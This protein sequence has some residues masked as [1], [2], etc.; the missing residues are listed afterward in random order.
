MLDVE[1]CQIL[2]AGN[3]IFRRGVASIVRDVVPGA[4]VVEA[5]SFA[6]ARARLN[7]AEFFAAIFDVD[8]DEL[9]GP[10]SFRTLRAHCPDVI[11]GVLSRT[12]S[13]SDI[14]SY[15]AAGVTGYVVEA[16]GQA[17]VERAVR[18]ILK[19]AIYIPP[20]VIEPSA[21]EPE[22]ALPALR[23]N[24]CHLTPRQNGVL[25]LVLRGYSNKE[26]ARQLNLSPHTVKIHVSALLRCFAVQKRSSLAVAAAAL[27]AD[28]IGRSTVRT[29]SQMLPI[30][31]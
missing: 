28:G 16:S 13:A 18:E 21:C 19:G 7:R 30:S 8:V 20:H 10:V 26:I 4:S 23:R 11:L 6:D 27:R 9:N 14:L 17:E 1:S 25:G 15:L 12:A 5:F 3:Y 29:S 22:F 2:I 24:G 31:V